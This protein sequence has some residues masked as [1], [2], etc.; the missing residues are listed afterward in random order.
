MNIFYNN[1]FIFIIILIIIYFIYK[2]FKQIYSKINNLELLIQSNYSVPIN[3]YN[4][5]I[6]F[7]TSLS[8]NNFLSQ[9][10]KKDY[11]NNIVYSNKFNDNNNI[12]IPDDNCSDNNLLN[13]NDKTE[14]LEIYS[15]DKQK[16]DEVIININDNNINELKETT[17]NKLELEKMKITELKTIAKELNI[18][19]YNKKTKT[20]LIYEILNIK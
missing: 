11:F 12:I 10:I 20:K 18:I 14:P 9:L 15:N 17:Y 3:K 2:E 7:D 6:D 13:E 1:L 5:I 4:N 8:F 19:D 16:S